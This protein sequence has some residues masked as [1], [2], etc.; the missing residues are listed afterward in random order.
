M[1]KIKSM[2]IEELD[3]AKQE[4]EKALRDAEMREYFESIKNDP[5]KLLELVNVLEADRDAR[6]DEDRDALSKLPIEEGKV[7]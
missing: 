6:R 1:K 7:S 4:A 2:T 3:Q 5:V